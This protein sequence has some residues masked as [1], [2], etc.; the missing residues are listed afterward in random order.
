MYAGSHFFSARF[1]LTSVRRC[2]ARLP[3][4]RRSVAIL[5]IYWTRRQLRPPTVDCCLVLF[6]GLLIRLAGLIPCLRMLLRFASLVQLLV[7]YHLLPRTAISSPVRGRSR[8]PTGLLG[9]SSHCSHMQTRH[10]PTHTRS[11][12][13]NCFGIRLLSRTF[14]FEI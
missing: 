8:I 11:E 10:L 12:P 5:L 14:T 2:L 4:C 1:R 7:F 3:A 9:S 13:L 6:N